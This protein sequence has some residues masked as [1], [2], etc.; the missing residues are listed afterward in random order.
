MFEKLFDINDLKQNE[1][2]STYEIKFGQY[3]YPYHLVN[4]I[5]RE[6]V[7][8][9]LELEG[10]DSFVIVCDEKVERLY[11]QKVKK[12]IQAYYTCHIIS[13]HCGEP[14]KNLKVLEQLI[15]KVLEL[16]IT[17]RTCIVGFGG[18]ICG[19]MAGMLS[20]MLF[21][22]IKFVHIPTSLMAMLDSVLS[23]K[24]A[25]N[26]SYGKN[27]IGFFHTP[28][29]VLANIEFL[30]TLPK[31]EIVS[32]MC[33]VVK[34]ALTIIPERIEELCNLCNAQ[35]AYS[36]KEYKFFIDISIKAKMAVMKEDPFE[37]EQGLIL[38]YG[39]TIGHA[40]ELASKG[41]ISHGEAVGLGMLCA[42]E[43]SHKMG[44]LTE[45]DVV[46]HTDLL[47]KIG[48]ITRIPEELKLESILSVMRFDNKRG[49]LSSEKGKFHMIIL[50]KIGKPLMNNGSLLTSVPEE[51]VKHAL[52]KLMD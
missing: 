1:I 39:H 2:C 25:I 38:E 49:Y 30:K 4:G 16:R 44:F 22:G 19:N 33:E 51:I 50:E 46:L 9:L 13:F 7:K 36:F 17:R 41:S 11:A 35:S 12:E 3:T 45:A 10:V 23:L 15:E 18:G 43:V 6:F 37:K 14:N 32:G 42:A 34:N 48:A 26:S 21:R 5:S 24:Q 8:P 47:K 28:D 40:I 29:M 20:A 52:K 31:A 27:L